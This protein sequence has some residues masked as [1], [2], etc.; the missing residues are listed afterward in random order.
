MEAKAGR[1]ILLVL[2]V[3]A[4]QKE[5]DSQTNAIAQ[6]VVTPTPTAIKST[7]IA[8]PR[9]LKIKVGLDSPGDLKVTTG[10][11]I[12]AG[13]TISDRQSNKQ[14]L[15][16]Q[17]Q[18]LAVQLQQ[19]QQQQQYQKALAQAQLEP[20]KLAIKNASLNLKRFKAN[21]R[22]TTRAYQQF[23]TL[24]S[25]ELAQE[26]ELELAYSSAKSA[27]KQAQSNFKAASLESDNQLRSLAQQIRNLDRQI[28]AAG[29]TRSPYSGT[30]KKI[31]FIGQNDSELL[32]EITIATEVP[33]KQQV[34]ANNL[35]QKETESKIQ[36]ST[37][38]ATNLKSQIVLSVH[39]GDTIRT[40]EYRIRLACIDSP[41]LKQPLGYQ[42]RDNLLKLISQSNNRIQLQIVDTDRYG[43]KVALIYTN[44][45]LLN[46]QQ[47]TDGMA[48]VYQ[49]YLNNCP[50][51][52]QVKQ[53]ENTAKQQKRGVWGG[54][55]QP[56]WE[57]RHDKRRN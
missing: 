2:L 56:P 46:L 48:Y 36:A 24:T 32:A 28:L 29:I 25:G 9:H 7:V 21:R 17:R 23:P 40:Q 22:Y 10:T 37:G 8:R 4:C 45:K 33:N 53:A 44:G 13:Q 12:Q 35:S 42:S 20:L 55:Y 41:E 34:A 3:T 6:T 49:K 5:R 15:I 14:P 43:R 31:K 1:I 57:F 50:Q 39:D 51:V 47:V 54:N 11:T 26:T 38:S 19:L 27:L 30:V 16:N 52:E 18:S